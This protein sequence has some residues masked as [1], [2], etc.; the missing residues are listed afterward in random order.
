[1]PTAK[2]SGQ[3]PAQSNVQQFK[4]AS[5]ASYAKS[6]FSPLATQAGAK[7]KEHAA[8]ILNLGEL[9]TIS[10]TAA[11]TAEVNHT[12]SASDIWI[13]RIVELGVSGLVMGYNGTHN[14]LGRIGAG[15]FAGALAET[16][17]D[18]TPGRTG[19]IASAPLP[20][21]VIRFTPREQER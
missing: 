21:H 10:V 11:V 4:S 13:W 15:V 2:K 12:R 20:D 8:I 3:K 19:Y 16:L 6:L 18:S 5:Q 7:G 17:V 1:M 9:A 14:T